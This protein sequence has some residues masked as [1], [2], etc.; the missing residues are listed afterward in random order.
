MKAEQQAERPGGLSRRDF[1][2]AALGILGAIA[3]PPIVIG[4]IEKGSFKE[5]MLE[6]WGGI[7]KSFKKRIENGEIPPETATAEFIPTVTKTATE[8]GIP[9]EVIVATITETPVPTFTPTAT[10]TEVPAKEYPLVTEYAR[11]NECFFPPE[12]LLSGEVWNWLKLSVAPTLV[13]GFQE[14]VNEMKL[15][16]ELWPINLHGVTVLIYNPNEAPNFKDPRTAPFER[17]TALGYTTYEGNQYEVLPVFFPVV[18]EQGGNLVVTDVEPMITVIRYRT[19]ITPENIPSDDVYTADMNS[20]PV[21]TDPEGDA[22]VEQSWENFGGRD[23]LEG[24]FQKALDKNS[25]L[26]VCKPGVLF[27]TKQARAN[28]LK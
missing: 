6:I 18:E 24:L 28:I 11:L 3:I 9:T 10:E 26:G 8:A 1:L 22:L 12:D 13:A 23:R 14:R 19:D 17:M 27:N 25:L 2:K 5:A 7:E 15:D 16:L 21:S 4:L 20:T